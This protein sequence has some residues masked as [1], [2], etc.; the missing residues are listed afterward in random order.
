[1][2]QT[3]LEAAVAELQGLLAESQA[4][5]IRLADAMESA[6]DQIND[7]ARVLNAISTTLMQE[8]P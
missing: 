5:V 8:R 2:A 4:E 3:D 6:E 1:M 7:A